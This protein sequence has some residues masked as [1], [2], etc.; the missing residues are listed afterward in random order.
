M[1]ELYYRKLLFSEI[2]RPERGQRPQS[3]TSCRNNRNYTAVLRTIRNRQ[4]TN[5]IWPNHKVS[6]I[7]QCKHRLHSRIDQ[8]QRRIAQ[9]RA[10]Q[11]QHN[12]KEQP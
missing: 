8:W 2:K 4:K 10:E 7:L 11:V 9:Q 12:T 1:E 5:T 6:K 3:S